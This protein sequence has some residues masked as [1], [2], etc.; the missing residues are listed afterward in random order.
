MMFYPSRHY[1]MIGSY[2]SLEIRLPYL[3]YRLINLMGHVA[4]KQK[5]E[6]LDEKSLLK[7]SFRDIVPEMIA[8]AESKL[9]MMDSDSSS[10]IRKRPHCLERGRRQP[11]ISFH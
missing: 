4:A 8:Q 7:K 11:S 10:E 2:N 9:K 6:V 5:M 3:D 1:G